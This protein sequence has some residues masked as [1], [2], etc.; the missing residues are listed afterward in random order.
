MSSQIKNKIN[1]K[2]NPKKYE[3][4]SLENESNEGGKLE[5]LNII[6]IENS[7]IENDLCTRTIP[8]L[9]VNTITKENSENDDRRLV[10]FAIERKWGLVKPGVFRR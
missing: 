3:G 7:S 8:S 1:K 10:Y 9:D 2:I 4:I 6:M 5:A